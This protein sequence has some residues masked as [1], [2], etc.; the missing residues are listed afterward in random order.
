M[1]APRA[2]IGR[3][4]K[5]PQ[6]L[7]SDEGVASVKERTRRTDAC[8]TRKSD[9]VVVPEKLPNK[10]APASAEVVEG[11]TSTE[12]NTHK[13]A[14][15]RTQSRARASFGLE[16]VRRRAKMDRGCRFTALMH[17]ITPDLLRKSFFELKK[18]AAPGIDG[19]TWWDYRETLEERLPKLHEEIQKGSYR[20]KPVLRTYIQKDD[21]GQRPL[22]VTTVEDKLVQQAVCTVIQQIYEADFIGFSYGFREG[23]G[24]HNALDALTTAIT[25]RRI[26]WVLDADLKSFFDTIPH[27]Q[28]L[29]LIE[30]RVADNRILRLI[31][32][33]L[34]T[35]YSEDGILHR[36][37]IGTPQGSVISPL[38]ANIYLHYVLDLW[39]EHERKMHPYGDIVIVRYADDFVLG[40]QR[41]DEAEHFLKRLKE[42]LSSFGLTLHPEKT[43]LI[44]FGR[45]AATNRKRRAQEK[46]EKFNFLGFTHICSVSTKGRFWIKRVTIRK[47]LRNKIREIKQ[48]LRKRISRPIYETGIWLKQL[49]IGYGNYHGVPGNSN[50]L[51]CFRKL[52][53]RLWLK[54]LRRRSQKGRKL[55]WERFGPIADRYIPL[56]R[57]CHPYP[58]VRFASTRGRSRMR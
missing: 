5:L 46:P 39:V 30:L 45:F 47:R 43:R 21:G 2:E 14:A 35:G 31:R 58:E 8:A 54:T 19:V 32:K 12:R 20:A 33:W 49:V 48:E 22:G 38:L 15:H 56:L 53:V 29:K 23:R 24:Q 26:S 7:A 36:Q 4:G 50:A 28:L 41:K 16:G 51:K 10:G 9:D 3:S 1:E 27:D 17:H 44:E 11:R 52:C 34:K 42:R 25:S 6:S 40:F 13:E 57:I 55:T 18:K 37:T